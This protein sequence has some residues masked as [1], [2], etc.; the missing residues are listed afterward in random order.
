MRRSNLAT[1]LYL[2]VVFA[3]GSVVGGFAVRLY[4]AR[5]VRAVTQ[6]A[7]RSRAEIRRQY[8]QEMRTRLSLTDVQVG[9]LQKIMDATGQRMHEMHKSVGDEHSRKVMAILADSQKAEYTKMLDEREKR[10]HE[11]GKK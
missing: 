4:M 8:I 7:P 3:S 6:N 10:R 9:E 11:S 1:L 5:E 2:V